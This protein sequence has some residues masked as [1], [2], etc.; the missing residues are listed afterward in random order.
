M[1]IDLERQKDGIKEE[2]I[3]MVW[4]VIDCHKGL[5]WTQFDDAEEGPDK[6]ALLEAIGILVDFIEILGAKLD[7]MEKSGKE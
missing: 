7:E 3:R 2:A 1:R 5:L 6:E 4:D